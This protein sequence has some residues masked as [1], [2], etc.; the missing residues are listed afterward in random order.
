MYDVVYADPPWRYANQA[1]R[2]GDRIEAHYPSMAL[3]DIKAISVPTEEDALLFL[4]ATSPL[5]PEALSV[6]VAWG[7]RYVTCGVWDKGSIGLGY[8]FRQQHELIFIGRKGD[9]IASPT[10]KH[11][12]VWKCRRGAHSAKPLQVRDW[13]TANYPAANGYRKVELFSRDGGLFMGELRE[14]WDLW[15]NEVE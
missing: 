12:S 5:V 10:I 8:W 7:F 14:E 9:G 3:E 11:S 2:P 15:G 6:M 13:I 1:P 4:W